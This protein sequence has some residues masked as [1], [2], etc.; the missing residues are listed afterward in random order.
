MTID[1]KATGLV[2]LEHNLQKDG[3]RGDEWPHAYLEARVGKGSKWS[4]AG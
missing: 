3:G 1:S 4:V 2:A